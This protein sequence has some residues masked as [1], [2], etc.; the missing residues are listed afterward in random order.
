MT[1][2]GRDKLVSILG[3]FRFQAGGYVTP[4]RHKPPARFVSTSSSEAFPLCMCTLWQRVCTLKGDFSD[5]RA[6]LLCTDMH[7]A[8][9]HITAGDRS[10]DTPP[11]LSG[12]SFTP[13]TRAEALRS[14]WSGVCRNHTVDPEVQCAL[15]FRTKPAD[16]LKRTCQ[17]VTEVSCCCRKSVCLRNGK[18]ARSRP[19]A[20]WPSLCLVRELGQV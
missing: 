6:M 9:P 20:H 1:L 11:R 12:I 7:Q 2:S 8:R 14:F 16:S 17:G 5:L 4:A 15:M 19:Y 3:Y 13:E 18:V 10:P